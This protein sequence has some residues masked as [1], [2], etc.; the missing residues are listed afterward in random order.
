MTILYQDRQSTFL[1]SCPLPFGGA[2]LRLHDVWALAVDHGSL[3]PPLT[4][5]WA[6]GHVLAIEQ[7]SSQSTGIQLHVQFLL[8]GTRFWTK[9]MKKQCRPQVALLE[10]TSQAVLPLHQVLPC[11]IHIVDGMLLQETEP[12]ERQGVWH[13]E[14]ACPWRLQGLAPPVRVDPSRRL[15]RVYDD[16][17]GVLAAVVQ[18]HREYRDAVD[19][20]QVS[21][22]DDESTPPASPVKGKRQ[23][24]AP[25]SSSSVQPP[26]A[27]KCKKT[28]PYPTQAQLLIKPS[29][30]AFSKNGLD[31]LSGVELEAQVQPYHGLDRYRWQIRI[32]DVIAVRD[33]TTVQAPWLCPWS[34]G[35]VLAVYRKND[36]YH[37]QLRWF[38][39]PTDLPSTVAL[40]PDSQWIETDEHIQDV[41]LEAALGKVKVVSS[42]EP[43]PLDPRFLQATLVC[44]HYY[45]LKDDRSDL[46][47]IQDW[48]VQFQT[49]AGPLSRCLLC[50]KGFLGK[51]RKLR[52]IYEKHLRFRWKVNDEL[53]LFADGMEPVPVIP[54][55]QSVVWPK[56][57]LDDAKVLL[58][59]PTMVGSQRYHRSLRISIQ[60]RRCASRAKLRNVH[61]PVRLGDVVCVADDEYHGTRSSQHSNPWHPFVGP[62]RAAQVLGI[63]SRKK[64]EESWIDVR[65]LLRPCDL[66][67]PVQSWMPPVVVDKDHGV[68]EVFESDSVG[69]VRATR[70]LGSVK[71][72]LGYHEKPCNQVPGVAE[73]PH[74][75]CRSR[76]AFS[77]E[78][79]RFSAVYSSSTRPHLWFRDFLEKGV[80]VAKKRK[81][82]AS[83]LVEAAEAY[84]DG[85]VTDTLASMVQDETSRPPEN[86]ESRILRRDDNT[87]YFVSVEVV[88]AWERIASDVFL[89]SAVDQKQAVWKVRVGDVIC[90]SSRRAVAAGKRAGLAHGDPF[91]GDWIV[92]QVVCIFQDA[93]SPS[94]SD[95]MSMRIRQFQ[96]GQ[97]PVS[98]QPSL[99]GLMPLTENSHVDDIVFSLEDA[100]APATLFTSLDMKDRQSTWAKV[101]PFLP[102]VPI[103]IVSPSG[104]LASSD[105][106][107][108]LIDRGIDMWSG[109]T[110]EDKAKL[111]QDVAWTESREPEG[112]VAETMP[113]SPAH[114]SLC[115]ENE[116]TGPFCTDEA[117]GRSYSE[118]LDV[119]PPFDQ[120]SRSLPSIPSASSSTWRIRMGDMVALHCN[121]GFTGRVVYGPGLDNRAKH[122]PLLV[123]FAIAEVVVIYRDSSGAT[124]LQVRWFYRSYELEGT[125][126]KSRRSTS[127]G[128]KCDEIF[129]TDQY[130]ICDP[131]SVLAPVQLHAAP[132]EV[133]EILQRHGAPVLEF[134]C[135][136]FWSV[137]RKSSVPCGGLSGRVE[138]GRVGSDFIASDPALRTA[139]IAL[140]EPRSTNGLIPTTIADAY[141]R[142]IE[143]LS[144]TDASKEV[145]NSGSALVG[146]E[147]ERA[148]LKDFLRRAIDG[149]GD[150]GSSLIFIGGPPGVGK[151]ASVR[152][153][154]SELRRDQA[155]GLL[156]RFEYVGLNGME[157]RSPQEAYTQLWEQLSGVRMSTQKASHEIATYF[158][159][160]SATTNDSPER[161]IVVLLDEID[162]LVTKKG[163]VLLD[164]FNWSIQ[165]FELC[166]PRRLVLLAVSNTLNLP[167]KLHPRV[168]SRIGKRRCFFK[169]YD[170]RQIEKILQTKL[171]EASPHIKVFQ[172]DAVT[173]ISKRIGSQSGDM[174]MALRLC[175]GA[176]QYTLEQA[177]HETVT[178]P[179]VLHAVRRAFQSPQAKAVALCAP[180]EVMLLI[181][182]AGLVRSTGRVQLDFED[183]LIK[184]DAVM[185]PTKIDYCVFADMVTRMVGRGLLGYHPEEKLSLRIEVNM[186]LGALKD[187]PHIR[188]AQKHLS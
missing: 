36:Q 130:D 162:L 55:N 183:I 24:T 30:V 185:N 151:T 131:D 12:V 124:K 88:P 92:G 113:K 152:S 52:D 33:G 143:K 164:F 154:I 99:D 45:S 121:H 60:P 101:T 4:E 54:S 119:K 163:A 104:K 174:R 105:I 127:R 90:I 22:D 23:S 77:V 150:E 46:D 64:S 49:M 32:G 87:A 35:Q 83:F 9:D 73:I 147:P 38:Y 126:P 31:F 81:L 40:P 166:C 84:K 70:I 86:R 188:L 177:D 168:Q 50:P 161:V 8:S 123:P 10:G 6:A 1:S 13:L 114:G 182:I 7:T 176:A 172:E 117:T 71:L 109:Y 122:F 93:G 47:V 155:A 95:A 140:S 29:S 107:G 137:Q 65:W 11:Q 133:S 89:C 25:P 112:R 141:E 169:A 106:S 2:T 20:E 79:T 91:V 18:A 34:P 75:A 173:F 67:S 48:K 16:W 94:G 102:I 17:K 51:Y 111:R 135:R 125:Q 63:R 66:P 187:T 58:D 15:E 53:R 78:R 42:D 170:S 26:P 3:Q 136:Q 153:V 59:E 74:V 85:D 181:A 139:I 21:E 128:L 144:L 159:Q 69:R 57:L 5:R 82:N 14:R 179:D 160:E 171:H 178:V 68:E 96:V 175:Q 116:R 158:S 100:L 149:S 180:G 110:A 120:Y 62:W 28:I 39:R 184:L 19:E 80:L 118:F 142:V 129:E 132:S 97:A 138:R 115:G 56:E 61:L 186:I 134:F 165:S 27:K 43:I 146:R 108:E 76:Y 44:R 72:F 148:L 167:E 157:M 41:P 156:R 37:V 103:A 145:E 98:L